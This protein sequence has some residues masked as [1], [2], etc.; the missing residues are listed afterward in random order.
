MLLCP[1]NEVRPRMRSRK[2]RPKMRSSQMRPK[3]R[4]SQ[5]RPKV[6]PSQVHHL[7]T[8]APLLRS[9]CQA[10]MHQWVNDGF[11]SFLSTANVEACTLDFKKSISVY[12]RD[13]DVTATH[14]A[15]Y[16]RKRCFDTS[17]TN[18]QKSFPKNQ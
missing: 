16:K 18:I 12:L 8:S 2:M 15:I 14:K 1:N 10:T 17:A 13:T 4:P 6:R 3:M 5:M 7:S 11:I 9:L